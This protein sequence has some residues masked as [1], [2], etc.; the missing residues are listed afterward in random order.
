MFSHLNLYRMPGVITTDRLESYLDAIPFQHCLPHQQRSAGFVEVFGLSKRVFSVGQALLFCL[1]AEE[2]RIPPS[3]LRAEFNKALGNAQSRGEHL[4]ADDRKA[5]KETVRNAMITK[6]FPKVTNTWAYIDNPTKT[7]VIDSSS[8]RVGDALARALKGLFPGSQICPLR[9]A[10]TVHEELARWVREDTAPSPF[11]LGDKCVVSDGEGTI[12]YRKRSLNDKNLKDYLT[13]N[14]ALVELSLKNTGRSMFCLT[15]DFLIK[16]F[17][18]DTS[19]LTAP[20]GTPLEKLD[21]EMRIIID[22][23]SFIS[24]RLIECLGGELTFVNA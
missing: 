22:E 24:K 5:L 2:K 6:V 15:D 23:V 1:S 9:P 20:S 7:L 4:N 16:D 12:T 14:M 19:L 13:E 21:A 11:V 18:L 3:A 17:E 8:R 10:L